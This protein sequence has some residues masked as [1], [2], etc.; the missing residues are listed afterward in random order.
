M[1]QSQSSSKQ[2]V[3][4]SI[5]N[6]EN[7][8][9]TLTRPSTRPSTAMSSRVDSNVILCISEGRGPGIEIGTASINLRTSECIL[10]QY[11]DQTSFPLTFNKFCTLEPSKVLISNTC[12]E[13][14]SK[15]I[16]AIGSHFNQNSEMVPMS[17]HFFNEQKGH[18][19]IKK[20]S[21]KQTKIN[22]S[23]VESKYFALS[24]LSALFSYVD[25]HQNI[26]FKNE[27]VVFQYRNVQGTMFIDSTTAR[28]LELVT[29][30][31]NPKSHTSLLGILNKT[32]T[33]MG[34]RLLRSSIL[35][36]LMIESEILDRQNS[37]AELMQDQDLM[38]NICVELQN[39]PDLDH[40]ITSVN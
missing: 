15:L 17:R 9:W 5:S 21:I 29:N 32:K 14:P 30:G 1:S 10:C 27:S 34:L 12:I 18:E 16:Q 40:L 28:Q 38:G 25:S 26:I 20:Y 36:P 23:G 8:P 31:I 13:P 22:L 33:A 35:Q 3:Q 7:R 4:S 11:S 6:K 24:A 19:I 37:V 39:Y 2:L